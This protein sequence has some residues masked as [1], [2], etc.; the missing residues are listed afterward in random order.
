MNIAID[1]TFRLKASHRYLLDANIISSLVRKPTGTVYQKLLRVGF[2]AVCT[3]IIVA[4]EIH[5]G[6]AKKRSET[7]NNTVLSI[8]SHIDVLGMDAPADLHYAEIRLELARIGRPVGANDLLIAAHAR[9]L[10]LTLVSNNT[11]EFERVPGLKLEDWLA[12]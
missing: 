5:F 4:A 6:L 2:E 8:L 10:N 12:Q 11:R 7:L 1:K 3:S 9:S